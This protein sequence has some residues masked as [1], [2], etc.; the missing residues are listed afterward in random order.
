MEYVKAELESAI[1][2]T[3]IDSD[4]YLTFDCKFENGQK[5]R[6]LTCISQ[7]LQ[8]DIISRLKDQKGQFY[9][10]FVLHAVDESSLYK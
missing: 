4:Y 7:E 2:L 8:D 1:I 5:I 6:F 9:G 10:T 3:T